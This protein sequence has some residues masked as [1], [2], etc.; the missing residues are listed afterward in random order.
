M[1]KT[2]ET[3]DQLVELFKSD[4]EFFE[5]FLKGRTSERKIR[6]MFEKGV[7]AS[8]GEF[9][10]LSE[11]TK[12]AVFRAGGSSIMDW[13]CW[14]AEGEDITCRRISTRDVETIEIQGVEIQVPL[15]YVVT[16][17]Q[18]LYDDMA[19]VARN[20]HEAIR[21]RVKGSKILTRLD[22]IVV[23][24]NTAYIVDVGESNTSLGVSDA[25]YQ[26]AGL[27]EGD[28]LKKYVERVI[29]YLADVKQVVLVAED[30]AMLKD[31]GY[32]FQILSNIILECYGLK[33]HTITKEQ[34]QGEMPDT[35]YIR[36]F[37]RPFATNIPLIDDVSSI[38][39]YSK[40]NI[41]KILAELT[42]PERI[43]A[44]KSYVIDSTATAEDVLETVR[45]NG[46][47]DFVVKPI[48][49]GKKSS[50]AFLYTVNNPAHTRQLAKAIRKIRSAGIKQ[51]MIEENIGSS[52]ADGRKLEVRVH[53]L[54]NI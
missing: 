50:I 42:L 4:K 45:E 52:V 46:L 44:P 32:E 17:P 34:L 11:A 18:K 21:K 14:H 41:L 35:G 16:L 47:E 53:C 6:Q 54:S 20:T 43:H 19:N 39:V 28:N 37:R 26:F 7:I 29:A 8:N 10:Y 27:G 38:P 2:V 49:K 22:Y 13:G 23:D 48:S 12:S 31:L 24:K 9:D 1:L 33:S 25:V 36:C 51:L 5:K 15:G 3:R 40:E 30:E